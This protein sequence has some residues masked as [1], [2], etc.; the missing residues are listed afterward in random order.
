[1]HQ[2]ASNNA[3]I[4]LRPSGCVPQMFRE[5]HTECCGPTIAPIALCDMPCQGKSFDI[6]NGY[7][8]AAGIGQQLLDGHNEKLE[9]TLI[10]VDVMIL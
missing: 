5:N 10:L 6:R 2:C 1:M 3:D 7:V 9:C 4:T 8:A